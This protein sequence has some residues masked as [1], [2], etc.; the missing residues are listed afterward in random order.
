MNE[1]IFI[2]KYCTNIVTKNQKFN[3]VELNIKLIL[4]VNNV[5]LSPGNAPDSTR[6]KIWGLTITRLHGIKVD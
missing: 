3:K 6:A 1:I 5:N 2:T 4:I